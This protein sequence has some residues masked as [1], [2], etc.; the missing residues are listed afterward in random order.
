MKPESENCSSDKI[1]AQPLIGQP[2]ADLFS[3]QTVSQGAAKSL[4][5][6]LKSRLSS[7]EKLSDEKSTKAATGKTA[8]TTISAV[9]ESAGLSVISSSGK[10]F[11]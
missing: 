6:L 8:V 5:N 3:S 7:S 10:L 1:P 2:T 11:A 4:A 9:T